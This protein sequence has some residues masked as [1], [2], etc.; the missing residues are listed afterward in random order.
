LRGGRF[1][2][3]LR[4]LGTQTASSNRQTAM[5]Q[6]VLLL[7]HQL[8]FRRLTTPGLGVKAGQLEQVFLKGVGAA[9][10]FVEIREWLKV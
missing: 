2:L 4:W 5:Q 9:H 3:I 6:V 7:F 1:A 8:A 10:G